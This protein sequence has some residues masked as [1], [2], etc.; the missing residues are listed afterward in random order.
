MQCGL[1][2]GPANARDGHWE[3]PGIA[4]ASESL[5]AVLALYAKA[6]GSAN[7]AYA[8]RVERYALV[9][10]GERVTSERTVRGADFKAVTTIDGGAFAS[11]RDSGV[12]WRRTPNGVTRTIS[13]DV[14]GDDLDRWPL[15]DLPFAPQD[16]TLAGAAEVPKPAWVVEY[17]P[18]HDVP[19]WFYIDRTSGDLVRETWRDG[20]V[21]VKLDFSDIREVD[22]DAAR[23]SL[24]RQ[25]NRPN[26][27]GHAAFRSSAAGLTER[28]RAATL[29]GDDVR[30]RAAR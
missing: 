10:G 21:V 23:L 24:D 11:G 18:A 26:R 29:E 17:H 27:R 13:I 20:S 19:H 16:C 9:A 15:A 3:P 25:R 4:P 2:I 30:R 6:S 7:P 12:R 5:A 28:R 8:Q 1:V 14:Q 22:G